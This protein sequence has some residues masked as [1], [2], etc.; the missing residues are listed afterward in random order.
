MVAHLR[1]GKRDRGYFES[2]ALAAL[3]MRSEIAGNAAAGV[4]TACDANFV[5]TMLGDPFRKIDSSA[6]FWATYS[7]LAMA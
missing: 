5:G 6:S 7:L 1:N 3:P 2:F 4:E